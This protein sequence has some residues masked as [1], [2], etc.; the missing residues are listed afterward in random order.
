MKDFLAPRKKPKL[1]REIW[2]LGFV[3]LCMDV[4]SESIHGLLPVFL[5]AVLGATATSVGFL[6]GLAEAT[7]LVMKVF[8]G[9]FS[10]WLGKRKPVVIIGYS[11]GALSKPLFALANSVGL[12]YGAR[13]FD[14][15][16]K[17][18]RGAPRDALVADIA[19]PE[20]RGRAFGLRQSLDTVGAFLGPALAILLMALTHN[21]YRIVFW[22]ATIPGL[23]AVVIL[24]TAVRERESHSPAGLGRRIQ[25][26]DLR[27]FSQN[28]WLV[29]G[30]GAVFQ[31]AR[32]SEA[33]LILRAKD[34]G[35]GLE[36][37]PLVLIVMNMVY[38]LSSYPVGY[39]SDHMRR[40]WFLFAGLI[41]LFFSDL[42][43]AFGTGLPMVFL[44]IA[45][46]GL[47]MGFTQGILTALV[48]DHCPT[49]LRGTA[50]G[51]FNLLS[52]LALLLASAIAGILWDAN[53]GQ[54]T[55]FA[56]GA[57][58]ALSLV[59]FLIV[60]AQVKRNVRS[61]SPRSD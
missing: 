10:D 48:A 11:M 20:M 5:V 37:S 51:L 53:G 9:P 60:M 1:P 40:E 38:A 15:V 36:F 21:N 3:S 57:A 23:L 29:A 30:A 42:A 12:V 7:A 55:F 44:G 43:L 26:K 16:G 28:F 39:L 14:R 49:V 33:F 22:L 32:F 24:F 59:V 46:W 54:A 19:P 6:E 41:L 52:A 31:L 27:S 61:P 4:A 50:Y 34:L 17:G 56:G 8:S 47:H 45:L 35:L 13:L 2:A 58:A 18:I 25:W